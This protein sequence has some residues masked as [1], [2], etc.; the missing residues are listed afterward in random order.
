MMDSG[1]EAGKSPEKSQSDSYAVFENGGRQYIAR[2]GTKIDLDRLDAKVGDK[3]FFDNVLLV[4][5]KGKVAIGAPYVDGQKVE[6]TV[7]EH[8]KGKK[9]RIIKFKRRKHHM[10]RG[11]ARR[12]YTQVEISSI[13]AKGTSAPSKS[14]APAK[15][16]STVA[17]KSP[18]TEATKPAATKS[19]AKKS[20][21]SQ[22][23][24][25]SSTND[26]V[27]A[28]TND[29]AKDSSTTKNIKSDKSDKQSKDSATTKS[30]S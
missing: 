26:S 5:D 21:S 19:P 20:V 13:D 25:K 18:V 23:S 14:A 2:L 11:T 9:I 15:P 24:V 16:A 22:A 6:A 17:P 1:K 29:S 4:S 30:D 28:S 12:H 10:K 3:I 27:K 8:G 7:I